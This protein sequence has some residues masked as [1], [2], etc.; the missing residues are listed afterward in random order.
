M[1]RKLF[2]FLQ[3]H[4]I[5]AS[6]LALVYY[7]LVVLPHE[8]VGKK[9][10]K[11][12][13]IPLGRD[14]YNL[15]ILSLSVCLILVVG[16]FILRGIRSLENESRKL[17]ILLF[18]LLI[19]FLVLAF[20]TII[21]I[22]IELIHVVQYAIMALLLFPIISNYRETLFWTTVFGAVDELYQYLVIAADKA[23]YYDFN[24]V[25][26]NLLGA[27]L[28]LLILRSMDFKAK[29]S[30]KNWISSPASVFMVLGSGLLLLGILLGWISIWPSGLEGKDGVI[31]EFVKKKESGFWTSL[32]PNVKFHVM[33]PFEGLIA[34]VILFNIFKNIG[35]KFAIN[36]ER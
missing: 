34:V 16:Y 33:R 27:A 11:Y 13:D 10:E 6:L 9:V 8:W 17:V 1:L 25:V 24:D 21:V 31:F 12:L 15:L 19:A 4:K 22:N 36:S 7:I 2:N 14:N 30:Y 20:N 23:N 35:Y 26:I 18:V 5:T 29:I 28:G 3:G 32:P